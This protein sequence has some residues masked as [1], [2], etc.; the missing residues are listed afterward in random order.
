MHIISNYEMNG[1]YKM[2]L[3]TVVDGA[4]SFVLHPSFLLMANVKGT[5]KTLELI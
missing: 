1:Y 3:L 2:P 4:P 5:L